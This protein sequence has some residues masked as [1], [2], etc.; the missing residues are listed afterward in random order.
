MTYNKPEVV[1]YTSLATIRGGKGVNAAFD[2]SV[3][4]S[5]PRY[6]SHTLT[7]NAYEADE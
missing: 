4:T 6:G 7:I 3:P 1:A 2:N 5:D